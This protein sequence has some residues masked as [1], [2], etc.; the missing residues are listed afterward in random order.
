MDRKTNQKER[1]Y[2]SVG[3]FEKEFFPKLFARKELAEQREHPEVHGT[4]LVDELLRAVEQEL[5][6]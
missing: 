6:K 3:E 4:G 1:E 5:K 2:C